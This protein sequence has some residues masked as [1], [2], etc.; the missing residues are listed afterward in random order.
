MHSDPL[1]AVAFPEAG[2][3]G[4]ALRELEL[5]VA[6]AESCTGGLLGAALTAVPGASDYVLG[7]V[8]VYANAV[9]TE[10]LGVSE[11]LLA[12]H[13]AV[14]EEVAVVMAEGVRAKLHSDVGLAITGVAGPD[15]EGSAKQPGLIWVACAGPGQA[16]SAVRDLEDIG[17][18]GNRATA[19]RLALRLCLAAVAAAAHAPS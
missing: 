5:T 16:V 12:T 7:G 2:Q 14:S 13:G 6:V 10:L 17:R 4:V 19:V 8:I 18:E 1:L 3:L 9:K 11:E 15:N